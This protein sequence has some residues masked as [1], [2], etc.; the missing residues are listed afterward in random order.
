MK[1][2]NVLLSLGGLSVLCSGCAQQVQEPKK[3]NI[4]FIFA[5]DMGYG[6]VSALNEN[7]KLKT[8]NIDR[9]ANEGV[10]F[11]DAHSSSSV[12]TPS[13]Y[14]L[15][16]GR[17][18]WRSDLKDGVL[19]GYDKALI[20][21]DRRT[22]ANVLGEC[23]Y[24]TAAIGKW[25][26][27][28]D[29]NNIEAG[30]ENVD[31]SQ[32]IT[33]G[34]TTRG[35][36]YYY[37]ISASLDM[38]P[39]VYVE[40]DKVTALPD[41]ET[42]NTGMGFWRKGPTGADFDH[43]QTLPHLIDKAV[44][45]IH[46]KS[47]EDKPF[48]LYL[49]LPAPHTPILPIK[50]YQGKSGLNPYGDFVLMVDDMVGKVMKALKD[51]GVEENTIIVFSTDNGCSPQAKFDELQEKGHYPSYIY[52][53][54]KAD[55]FDGGHRIPCVV[56]W[57]ARIKPH[58]VDQTICL[59]DFFAT[60]AAVADYRLKDTEGEDSY[61]IL[62]LLLNEKESNVIREATVH[63]S[64]NGEFTIRKGD[65]KLLLSPSSG[66]WSFPKPGTDDE[67]IKTLPLVQLYNM[68]EDPAETNNVY[69]EHPEIV[70]ELKDLMVKYV[71]DGRSTPGAPQ[72]N[73]GPEIW[74]QLSW[75]EE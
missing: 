75:M 71:K 33:N 60:F 26:L 19:Y 54:H 24:Q 37:G 25:H 8:T 43:E 57:P 50:E 42:V 31:F 62:P 1:R 15:L 5:D 51:A 66:G 53:G 38:A 56:R 63:H 36:D 12:S 44:G 48:Y 14:S 64:I 11:T 45:Y 21:Q 29:W 68:K 40:N 67:V 55:L 2:K 74:K 34:P 30:P 35:F 69:A 13:R 6:D 4:V 27:G 72:K 17:Y 32:P 23:G 9:I 52:R 18:N 3:P 58:V 70:K 16:T 73:D 47:K 22:I 10:I 41:R 28:W 61:N 49:P 7:S 46:D 39:Y 59:T 20:P 65:W